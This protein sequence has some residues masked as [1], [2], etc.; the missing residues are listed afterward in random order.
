MMEKMSAD[1]L[2]V[3]DFFRHAVSE[4]RRAGLVFGHGTSDAIDEAAFLVLE[5]L[6]L[7]VDDINPWLDARLAAPER[8]R[9]AE[10]VAARV[11][12]R[13][14]AAY[15]LNRAY[16]QG[17]PFYVDERVIVPRSFIAEMLAAGGRAIPYPLAP[18]RVETVLDLCTG[19]GCLAILAANVYANAD[20]DAADISREA[21]DVAARNV[22]DY[23][24]EDRVRLHA[25][26]LFAPLGD[27]RYDLIITNPPYVDA[28][29]MA[30][31]PAEFRAEPALAL[32][33]GDDGLDVVRRILEA[34]PARLTPSGALLCEIGR[35][36]DI[37]EADYPGFDFVWLDSA[38]SAG[39]VFFLPAAAL[40]AAA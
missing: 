28:E 40:G 22:A 21:L 4:F 2:T 33:G 15:L 5:G 23:G 9:L 6:S 20:I 7:P 19:S 27:A 8:A 3:R 38:E 12:T 30:R 17:A 31:L 36:R 32:A 26:D 37:L 39:E 10:L 25:G 35:G 24:L 29:A 11:A 14:P 1:F 18:E 16:I 34:A 13:K